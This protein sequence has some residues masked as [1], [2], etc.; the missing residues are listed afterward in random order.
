MEDIF[1]LEEKLVSLESEHKK[2]DDLIDHLR[3]KP[4]VNF[5][6]LKRL[7]KKKLSLKDQ[8]QK[9]KSDI[10]PDIIA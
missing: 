1:E 5:L 10:I 2:L 6:E 4:P 8:I 3:N 9:V 7:Q